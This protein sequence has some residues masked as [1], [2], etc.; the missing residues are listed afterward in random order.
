MP[1]GNP[2]P[3]E[4]YL[5]FKEKLY[6]IVTVAKHSETGEALVIYQ[7][8]YGSFQTY[9][10]PL[11]MFVSPVDL[12]KYPNAGQTYRFQLVELGPQSESDGA[13]MRQ[14]L[15]ADSAPKPWKK[16]MKFCWI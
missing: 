2:K 3:G 5:H 14:T 10:R 13:A 4:L 11:E 6:Q 15:Q 16:N 12:D 1:Q 8:L 9:A 7:A